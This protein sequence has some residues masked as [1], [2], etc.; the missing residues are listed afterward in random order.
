MTKALGAVCCFIN[1]ANLIP[2]ALNISY[3]LERSTIAATS[4]APARVTQVNSA[5]AMARLSPACRQSRASGKNHSRRQSREDRRGGRGRVVGQ[6]F[7][8]QANLQ[9]AFLDIALWREQADWKSAS[10]IKSCPTSQIC[11]PV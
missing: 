5:T 11:S 6:D 8:L 1:S 9:L 10:R 3:L 2:S 7:I 4:N